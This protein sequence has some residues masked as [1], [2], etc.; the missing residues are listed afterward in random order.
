MWRGREAWGG[1]AG[2]REG[3]GGMEEKPE[4][5]E[6]GRRRRADEGSGLCPRVYGASFG[7]HGR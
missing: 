3:V 4:A 5:P 7:S 2:S 1:H 6:R